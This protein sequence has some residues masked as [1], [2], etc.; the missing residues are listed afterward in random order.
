MTDGCVRY[1]KTSI[2]PKHLHVEL[3]DTDTIRR[4]E[5]EQRI[6][7]AIRKSEPQKAHYAIN[8]S[9][10]KADAMYMEELTIE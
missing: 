10:L 1:A 2:T 8:L 4:T 3:V 5:Y 9:R 7:Q 6:S